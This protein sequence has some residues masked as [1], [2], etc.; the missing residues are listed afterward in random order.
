[1][2]ILGYSIED[3]IAVLTFLGG[4]IFGLM[5]FY[6]L[7][8]RMDNTLKRLND[9]VNSIEGR[10]EAHNTRLTRLEEQNKTIFRRMEEMKND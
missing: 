4:I 8:T 6:A 2:T 7:F 10:F 9:T 3:W 1:M 5:K